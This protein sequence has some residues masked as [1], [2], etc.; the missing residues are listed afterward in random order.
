M[1]KGYPLDGNLYVQ[2][3]GSFHW[4]SVP[5]A[6]SWFRYIRL[7]SGRPNPAAVMLLS[8]IIYRYQPIRS[9]DEQG[10][11]EM[12]RKRFSGQ[13]VRLDYARFSEILGFTRRQVEDA[14]VVLKKVGFVNIHVVT[15]EI[16]PKKRWSAIS[17]VAPLLDAI[18]A[19]TAHV[20]P[21]KR[22]SE[23]ELHEEGEENEEETG[24]DGVGKV[25]QLVGV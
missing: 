11:A 1:F 8:E 3:V 4:W 19:I 15:E 20:S 5:L 13:W 12:D 24:K 22:Q 18:E 9:R 16:E 10:E 14:T 17:Y 6:R 7:A 21:S 2:R 25:H 23:D